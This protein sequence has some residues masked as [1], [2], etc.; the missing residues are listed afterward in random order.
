[1][2]TSKS[3]FDQGPFRGRFACGSTIITDNRAQWKILERLKQEDLQTTGRGAPSYATLK[4]RCQQ[5]SPTRAAQA[6]TT[7]EPD[8]LY[9]YRTLSQNHSK[10]TPKLLESRKMTQKPAELVPGGFIFFVAWEIVPGLRLGDGTGKVDSR[11][12]VATLP[13]PVLCLCASFK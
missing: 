2:S 5:D 7:F 3:W 12:A 9:A 4:L 6:N 1:M 13:S 11:L 8:E 10:C